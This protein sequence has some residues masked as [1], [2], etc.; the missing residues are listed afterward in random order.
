MIAWTVR[1]VAAVR[2]SQSDG[3]HVDDGQAAAADRFG[4]GVVDA[5]RLGVT[6]TV[7]DLD[8]DSGLVDPPGGTDLTGGQRRRVPDRVGEQL[9]EYELRVVAGVLGDP[10][11]LQVGG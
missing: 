6:A 9:R 5:L 1:W 3:E 11:A 2:T 4:V 7:G 10:V 8:V